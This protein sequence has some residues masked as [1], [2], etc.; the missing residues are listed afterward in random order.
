MCAYLQLFGSHGDSRGLL[1]T[2]EPIL[3][4]VAPHS[5]ESDL[6]L[7]DDYRG[8]VE[9]LVFDCLGRPSFFDLT[10]DLVMERLAARI[11]NRNGSA[12]Q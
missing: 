8:L 9:G 10:V 1:L 12:L 5:G 4:P 3:L 2:S 6:S 11:G 7:L